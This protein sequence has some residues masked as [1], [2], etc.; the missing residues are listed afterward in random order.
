MFWTFWWTGEL[1]GCRAGMFV[2]PSSA[3]WHMEASCH[4][5]ALACLLSTVGE[6]EYTVLTVSLC[7]DWKLVIS[8]LGAVSGTRRE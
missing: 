4:Q 1:G 8:D 2:K 5:G 6:G 3:H 7:S